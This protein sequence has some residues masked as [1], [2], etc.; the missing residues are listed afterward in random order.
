MY[1]FRSARSEIVRVDIYSRVK[2]DLHKRGGA[3]LRAVGRLVVAARLRRAD[4]TQPDA[5]RR[6]GGGG[7]GGWTLARRLRPQQDLEAVLVNGARALPPRILDLVHLQPLRQ[8]GVVLKVEAIA[9]H[10][11]VA[12]ENDRVRQEDDDHR[13][14]THRDVEARRARLE[15]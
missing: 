9:R 13:E 2:T 6:R 8:V 15:H 3:L 7:G 4:L 11:R 14:E 10:R 1:V 5:P 12:A